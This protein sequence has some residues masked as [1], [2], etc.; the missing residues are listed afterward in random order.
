MNEFA[1]VAFQSVVEALTVG[2][3]PTVSTDF[4]YAFQSFLYLFG[5]TALRKIMAI[6]DLIE[7]AFRQQQHSKRHR[8]YPKERGR[9]SPIVTKQADGN[10]N[11]A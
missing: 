5:D 8:Y 9:Q 2:L 4:L 3:F 6:E 1:L 10:D 11:H 7:S